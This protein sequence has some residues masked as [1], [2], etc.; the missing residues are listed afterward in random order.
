MTCS[1]TPYLENIPKS[2][3]E[4]IQSQYVTKTAVRPSESRLCPCLG[5]RDGLLEEMTIDRM[6]SKIREMKEEDQQEEKKMER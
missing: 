1:T 3:R 2:N 5:N 6:A 4:T